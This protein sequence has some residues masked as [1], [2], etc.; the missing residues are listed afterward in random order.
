MKQI[1][2]SKDAPAPIGPYA[3][4]VS[5]GNTLYCSGQIPLDAVSGAMCG[6][7]VGAQTEKV[8]KNLKAVLAAAGLTFDDIVKTTC[9][10][11]DMN[12]FAEFNEAYAK[13]FTKPHARACVAVK[14]LPKGALVEIDAI[15]V[16]SE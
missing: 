11:T 16:K 10:L 3:Q 13:F 6:E 1:I 8:M 9:Y 12:V 4:A 7:T 15:A 2:F 5:A 14:A